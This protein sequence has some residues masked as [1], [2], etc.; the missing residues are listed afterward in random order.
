MVWTKTLN[1]RTDPSVHDIIKLLDVVATITMITCFIFDWSLY[2]KKFGC[3]RHC[4]PVYGARGQDLE[5][6]DSSILANC[7][8][9]CPT[10]LQAK[11]LEVLR[12]VDLAEAIKKDSIQ[13]WHD[14][15]AVGP[16]GSFQLTYVLQQDNS[17]PFLDTTKITRTEN[18]SLAFDVYIKPTHVGQYVMYFNT[19]Y[20]PLLY[21]KLV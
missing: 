7:H 2:Q 10:R 11:V 6:F 5:Y 17:L 18:S 16:T 15:I 20:H 21:L 1:E 4:W 3:H 14:L 13:W 9:Y 12:Y 8:I 19:L